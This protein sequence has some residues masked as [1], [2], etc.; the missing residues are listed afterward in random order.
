MLWIFIHGMMVGYLGIFYLFWY[1]DLKYIIGSKTRFFVP[2]DTG[3]SNGRL[4]LLQASWVRNLYISKLACGA[5]QSGGCNSGI[6]KHFLSCARARAFSL[7]PPPFSTKTQT[8]TRTHA[9][10][11]T[12]TACVRPAVMDPRSSQWA[13]AQRELTG[14]R[15]PEPMTSRSERTLPFMDND[16]S[17]TSVDKT[18]VSADEDA[19]TE[20]LGPSNI[21]NFTHRHA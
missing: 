8:H 16:R 7:T 5:L 3:E 2:F 13:R 21:R 4:V 11:R 20:Q 18:G 17:S 14:H 6:P 9:H 1:S 10:T 15:S 12:H 19:L